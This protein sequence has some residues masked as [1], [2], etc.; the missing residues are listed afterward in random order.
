MEQEYKNL[1]NF[2]DEAFKNNTPTKIDQK[3][4]EDSSFNDLINTYLNENDVL[5][6]FGCGMGWAIFEI[7]NSKKLKKGYGIDPSKNAIDY[8]NECTKLSNFNNLKFII[9]DENNLLNLND[10]IDSLISFNV[11]DVLPDDVLNNVLINIHK[12]VKKEGIILLG[13]NPDFPV[14]FLKQLG[15]E[16]KDNFLYKDNVLR[17]NLKSDKDWIN[18]FKDN[19][20]FIEIRKVSVNEREAKFPRRVFV[21]KNK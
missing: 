16:I 11:I 21:L 10:K 19:F 3:W 6:D 18:L 12:A 4:I 5:V 9:G 14:D 8:C 20:D 2:W 1:L 17:G 7:L 13:I 15:Y